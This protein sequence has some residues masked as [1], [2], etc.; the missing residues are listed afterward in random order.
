MLN[1]ISKDN[2]LDFSVILEYKTGKA[3]EWKLRQMI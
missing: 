3:Q 2:Y 1:E